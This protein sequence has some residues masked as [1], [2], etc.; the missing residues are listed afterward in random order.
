MDIKEYIGTLLA[1]PYTRISREYIG[2]NYKKTFYLRD[3]LQ[4]KEG[5]KTLYGDINC[6]LRENREGP[7]GCVSLDINIDALK[8]GEAV[9]F[10]DL[11]VSSRIE[12]NGVGKY[13]MLTAMDYVKN[14]KEYFE[15]NGTVPLR[16]WL[17]AFDAENGNWRVS[18]PL[19][20]TVGELTGVEHFFEAYDNNHTR[21]STPELFYEN[22][23]ECGG[24]IVYMI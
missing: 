10:K 17:S 20:H 6:Y 7:S 13:L 5:F 2:C 23:S 4:Y 14:L 16:G 3:N 1:N 9:R 15:F 18:L 24:A 21:Y 8:R 12:N 11:L 22:A 19:Y